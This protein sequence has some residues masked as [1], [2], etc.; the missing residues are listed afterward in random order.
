MATLMTAVITGTHNDTARSF[1]P[2]ST[3][4]AIEVSPLSRHI[5]DTIEPVHKTIK[6]LRRI[7]TDS[8]LISPKDSNFF[9]T[10]NSSTISG[11]NPETTTQ[12]TPTLTTV[13]ITEEEVFTKESTITPA[14][15]RRTIS[16]TVKN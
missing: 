10:E 11:N 6:T 9:K 8:V 12:T 5:S 1:A 15:D 16:V 7:F 2:I 4:D 3:T 14:T 13:V